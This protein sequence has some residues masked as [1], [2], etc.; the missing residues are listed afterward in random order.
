MKRGY[1]TAGCGRTQQE[2]PQ[3]RLTVVRR[4]VPRARRSRPETMN[5]IDPMEYPVARNGV[6]YW[7]RGGMALIRRQCSVQRPA[8]GHC[9]SRK[10]ARSAMAER[11]GDPQW[12]VLRHRTTLAFADQLPAGC[13]CMAK[14]AGPVAGQP[15]LLWIAL[16]GGRR[17]ALIKFRRSRLSS[18]PGQHPAPGA[19]DPRGS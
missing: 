19:S 13:A 11:F 12:L 9:C 1:P 14:H 15:R 8:P 6:R 18:L 3:G 10:T 17:G 16:L 7:R 5:G 4:G 2:K